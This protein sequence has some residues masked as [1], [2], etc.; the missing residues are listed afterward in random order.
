MNIEHRPPSQNPKSNFSNNFLIN[1]QETQNP[2]QPS[3]P[4]KKKSHIIHVY[5][6]I[7]T[8]PKSFLDPIED[9]DFSYV[10]T[11]NQ[12]IGV[13]KHS[14]SLKGA[15]MVSVDIEK[16]KDA[17]AQVYKNLYSRNSEVEKTINNYYLKNMKQ[18]RLKYKT[19]T[20]PKTGDSLEEY[21]CEYFENLYS[22]LQK[23]MQGLNSHSK[24][25]RNHKKWKTPLSL[26]NQ[27]N[28]PYD[29]NRPASSI[30]LRGPRP[31]GTAPAAHNNNANNIIKELQRASTSQKTTS[32]QKENHPIK[33]DQEK[34]VQKEPPSNLNS[35]HYFRILKTTNLLHKPA[36]IKN[37]KGLFKVKEK[38]EKSEQ[39][40]ISSSITNLLERLYLNSSKIILSEESFS[41]DGSKGLSSLECPSKKLTSTEGDTLNEKNSG[42]SLIHKSQAGSSIMYTEF[43]KRLSILDR[44]ESKE[45][46]IGYGYNAKIE[47]ISERYGLKEQTKERVFSPDQFIKNNHQV[48]Q[49]KK[50]FDVDS[51]PKK[52]LL[53]QNSDYTIKKDVFLL[54]DYET[55]GP[56]SFRKKKIPQEKNEGWMGNK[57]E[58][59]SKGIHKLVFNR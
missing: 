23:T 22:N 3:Q 38:S 27:Y 44:R 53:K 21:T 33:E 25:R 19:N 40:T 29:I 8:A 17:I 30:P 10:P 43:Q 48:L 1:S 50:S 7:P 14:K 49:R 46:K 51:N 37:E 26:V 32:R 56:L 59:Y 5:V 24:G 57:I 34:F 16:K 18:E 12:W 35:D 54:H 36:R 47:R 58:N 28:S 11:M 2:R 13:Y 15:N 20:L 31:N 6:K 39:N 52:R 55:Q 9:L 42:L 4:N 41:P 45:N